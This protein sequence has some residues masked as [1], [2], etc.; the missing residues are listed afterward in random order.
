MVTYLKAPHGVYSI[1]LGSG[2]AKPDG[3]NEAEAM[4]VYGMLLKTFRFSQFT[5]TGIDSFPRV[6]R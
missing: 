1:T 4:E 3:S 6:T 5:G 2:G